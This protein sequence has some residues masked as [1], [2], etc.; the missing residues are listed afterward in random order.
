MDAPG[1]RLVIHQRGT[2][3]F[4]EEEGITLNPNYETSIGMRMVRI[5]YCPVIN[6]CSLQYFDGYYTSALKLLLFFHVHCGNAL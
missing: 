6:L 4:P 2:L 3:P 5:Y 1:I